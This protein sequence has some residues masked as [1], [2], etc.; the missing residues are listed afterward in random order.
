LHR[1]ELFDEPSHRNVVTVHFDAV[2]V[3]I[4]LT[5]MLV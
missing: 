4:R 3:G 2:F 5:V 1:F